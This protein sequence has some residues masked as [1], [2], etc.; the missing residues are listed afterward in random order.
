MKETIIIF[1]IMFVT[2]LIGHIF[3][4][5]NNILNSVIVLS[6][7][8]A[9]TIGM[10]YNIPKNYFK[11]LKFKNLNIQYKYSISY[12]NCD[13]DTSEFYN[14]YNNMCKMYGKQNIK[15]MNTLEGDGIY[16]KIITLKTTPMEIQYNELNSKIYIEIEDELNYKNL[17]KKI[18]KINESISDSFNKVKFDKSIINLKILFDNEKEIKNPFV[19]KFFGDF[20]EDCVLNFTYKTKKNTTIEITNESIMFISNTIDSLKDDLNNELKFINKKK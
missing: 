3:E 16:K 5:D 2:T 10:F 13:I 9:P 14:I 8:A 1:I 19:K 12:S 17:I 11:Y 4:I 15:E 18:S 7:I 6:P 20:G